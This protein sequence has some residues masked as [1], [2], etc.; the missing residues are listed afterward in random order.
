MVS[1]SP[2]RRPY[3]GRRRGQDPAARIPGQ[4]ARGIVRRLRMRTLVTLGVLAVATALL[5]RGFGWR[6]P[7]FL[8]SEVGLL[9]AIFIVSRYV[10][11]LVDRHDRGATGEERV[12]ALLQELVDEGWYVIHDASLG[13][14]N[15]DHIAIGAP[16]L[17]TVET[18]SHPG[19]VRVARVHGAAV[20]QAL[21]QQRAI[22]R[23]SG[24]RVQPLLVFSR[25]WVDRPLA[26]RRG[27]RVVPAGMLI[28]FLSRQP[29]QLS[30]AEVERA[31]R[32][33]ARALAALGPAHRR[34]ALRQRR[35]SQATGVRFS[36]FGDERNSDRF[37]A[38]PHRRGPS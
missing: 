6:D 25:A 9:V 28:A 32:R 23:V 12:G 38:G 8:G 10:L 20:A 24:E 2:D 1:M 37:P 22:E 14:G 11:P 18:K 35:P 31:H 36:L 17:F 7:V 19:P 4:H 13:N 34:R 27:V 5:G 21:S 29:P 33:I 16:G 26:R 15:I 30:P 3:P